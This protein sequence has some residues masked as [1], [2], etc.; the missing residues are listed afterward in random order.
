MTWIVNPAVSVTDPAPQSNSVG[1]PVSLQLQATDSTG[2]APTFTAA[3][4]PPGPQISS[5]GLITGSPTADGSYQVTVTA[6]DGVYSGS[7]TFGWQVGPAAMTDPG[8]QTATQGGA[9]SLQVQATD[10]ESLPLDYS[11]DDLPPGLSIN[12]QTGQITGTISPSASGFYL[13]TVT[14]SD[15]DFDEASQTF[16]WDVSPVVAVTDPGPQSGTEGQAVAL[17]LQA[18]DTAGGTPTFALTSGNLPPGLQISAGGLVSGTISAGAAAQ[19]PYFATVT[20][21]DGAYSGTQ[22]VFWSVSPALTIADPGGQYDLEG[23]PVNVQ[24]QA[25]DAT[26]GT[27][28]FAVTTGH[29]PSGLSISS[30]GL[31]TGTINAGAAG[32]YQATVTATD[33]PYSATQTLTWKVIA[34]PAGTWA[35]NVTALDTVF[36][37]LG[38]DG[39]FDF[40]Q[41]TL[42][43]AASKAW[44]G[45]DE[46]NQPAQAEP[47]INTMQAI[48][49]L[50]DNRTVLMAETAAKAAP[51]AAAP[52]FGAIFPGQDDYWRTTIAAWWAQLP[53]G[54]QQELMNRLEAVKAPRL[55]N[56]GSGSLYSETVQ[57]QQ[58]EILTAAYQKWQRRTS[59]A[60][61]APAPPPP[62]PPPP[63]PAPAPW[64]QGIG[65][66]EDEYKTWM[67][68]LDDAATYNKA[69]DNSA[70]RLTL[71]L[72][73]GG[74]LPEGSYRDDLIWPVT[75]EE[76]RDK[77]YDVQVGT[78]TIIEMIGFVAL[79]HKVP[80]GLNELFKT[81]KAEKPV[82]KPPAPKESS[83]PP[84]IENLPRMKDDEAAFQQAFNK[85]NCFAAGTPLLTPDGTRCIDELRPGDLLLSRSES[86][87]DGPLVAKVVEAAFSRLGRILHLHVGGEVIRTT[88]EPRRSGVAWTKLEADGRPGRR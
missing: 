45:I 7:D 44:S 20:A 15:A 66:S 63:P 14:A 58:M 6:S 31:I 67:F 24:L 60:K 52:D 76:R 62:P 9:V 83:L 55:V 43:A 1:G 88:R 70:A 29:L 49:G 8:D 26:G 50:G 35:G 13:T 34:D 78:A 22:Q 56:A 33:G 16:S 48:R 53:P 4:L 5:G 38:T 17:Q 85:G 57:F 47:A 65:M 80:P 32:N 41:M 37:Y 21:T 84:E 75:D 82:A 86:D 18:T 40:D 81:E 69:I 10:A 54:K 2:G 64:W 42:Q 77:A 27:P 39:R 12:Q 28:T 87:P 46:V 74:A 68:I 23:D 36:R 30:S 11:A 59:R 72:L 19:G 3:G 51:T 71:L 79:T 25:T 73:T 61:A